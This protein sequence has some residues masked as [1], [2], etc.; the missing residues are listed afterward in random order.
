MGQYPGITSPG[1][2]SQLRVSRCWNGSWYFCLCGSSCGSSW[3]LNPLDEEAAV[4]SAMC[5]I[6]YIRIY[7][8]VKQSVWLFDCRNFRDES[9]GSSTSA[10][11]LSSGRS[12]TIDTSISLPSFWW[13]L[14]GLLGPDA[15]SKRLGFRKYISPILLPLVTMRLSEKVRA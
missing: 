5:I 8:L 12:K 6:S 9:V 2:Q 10:L 11:A 3:G 15:G 13:A 4:K 1:S 14:V 7:H